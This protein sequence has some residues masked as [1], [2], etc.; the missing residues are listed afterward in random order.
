MS[1]TTQYWLCYDSSKS[2]TCGLRSA[3]YLDPAAGV[4]IILILA[5]FLRS[6]DSEFRKA[7]CLIRPMRGKW[8]NCPACT[9]DYTRQELL[10]GNADDEKRGSKEL[11][12]EYGAKVT[13]TLAAP[14][15]KVGR[16]Q[17]RIPRWLPVS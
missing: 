16:L 2:R 4:F 9:F 12:S 15:N 7:V 11:V 14:S 13:A 17:L 6:S 1:C 5:S 8:C 3:Y 10:R